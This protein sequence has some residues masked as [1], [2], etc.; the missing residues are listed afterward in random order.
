MD[1]CLID[2]VHDV[3]FVRLAAILRFPFKHYYPSRHGPWVDRVREFETGIRLGDRTKILAAIAAITPELST[4]SPRL[5]FH[6][7]DITW[8]VGVMDRNTEWWTTVLSMLLAVASA[9][10]KY[11]SP[12]ELAQ[13]TSTAESTWRL[14]AADGTVPG[15]VKKGK[16]WLLCRSVILACN[17]ATTE[18]LAGL[19][20]QTDDE[21]RKTDE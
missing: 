7:D 2:V 16:Q 5:Q 14:Y 8:L 1:E 9:T 3:H 12:A 17:L 19:D 20:G 4:I 11:Y 15:A 10:D 13:V 6:S 18:Q 21:E